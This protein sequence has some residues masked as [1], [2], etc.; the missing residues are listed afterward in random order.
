[1]IDI[2]K[3]IVQLRKDQGL[4]QYAL[5]KKSDV[6]QGALSQYESGSKTPSIDTLERICKALGVSMSEFFRIPVEDTEKRAGLSY[7]EE[8]LLRFYRGL[9]DEDKRKFLAII[10]VIQG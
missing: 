7:S 8:E 4:S 9:R 6:T 10:N 3:R 1:M 2:A 5:W